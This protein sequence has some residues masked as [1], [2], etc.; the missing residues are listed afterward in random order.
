MV[1]PAGPPLMDVLAKPPP[2]L[3][4]ARLR[5]KLL[6]D[7]SESLSYVGAG[8]AIDFL[9]VAAGR[10]CG[11]AF[12]AATA[13]GM[14]FFCSAPLGAFVSTGALWRD[15]ARAKLDVGAASPRMLVRI[16]GAVLGPGLA[17][18]RIEVLICV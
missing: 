14:C 1:G 5:W 10:L 2:L 18:P 6:A 8:A 13:A 12:E 16:C 11:R 15:A 17:F 7:A 9:G 4:R 3:R